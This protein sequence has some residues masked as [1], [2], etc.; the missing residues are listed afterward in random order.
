MITCANP[1]CGRLFER[2]ATRGPV[3]IYCS[4]RCKH[5]VTHLRLIPPG[6]YAGRL[7]ASWVNCYVVALHQP[8]THGRTR[9]KSVR[10]PAVAANRITTVRQ[11]DAIA[12]LRYEKDGCASNHAMMYDGDYGICLPCGHT[13]IQGGWH[14]D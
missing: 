10:S 8:A 1:E 5:R 11:A 14:Y 4:V 12:T 3:P 2:R 9:S 13:A 6:T 7:V